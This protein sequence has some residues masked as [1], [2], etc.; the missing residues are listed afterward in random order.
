MKS[1]Q[2]ADEDSSRSTSTGWHLST[3]TPCPSAVAQDWWT[4]TETLKSP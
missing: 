1:L 3:S 4:P 2:I